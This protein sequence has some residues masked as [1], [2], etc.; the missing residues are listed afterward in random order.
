MQWHITIISIVIIKQYKLLLAVSKA[1][2][3][4]RAKNNNCVKAA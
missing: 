3:V 2:G 1:T 4:I